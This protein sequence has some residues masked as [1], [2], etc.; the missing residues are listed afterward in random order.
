[1]DS[2]QPDM[3]EGI[4][5][6]ALVGVAKNCGKT[7]TLNYLL[8]SG[9]C[10][11]RV[12]GLVSIGIDGESAD[13][14]IGTKKPPIHVAAGQWVLPATTTSGSYARISSHSRGVDRSPGSASP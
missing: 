6:L 5:R 4:G 2:V 1:M 7:T 8:G 12:V 14:L 11:G 13:L 10:S 9:V 3:L